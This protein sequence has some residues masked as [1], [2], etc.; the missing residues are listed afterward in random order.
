MNKK[1]LLLVINSFFKMESLEIAHAWS[2]YLNFKSLCDEGDSDTLDYFFS[3]IEMDK[4]GRL[5][6]RNLMAKNGYELTPCQL[7][8]YI[9]IL[10]LCI[11]EFID[12]E[13]YLM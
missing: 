11:N 2:A 12:N 6:L 13:H 3:V 8:Q 5:E 10:R 7:E 4:A 1:Q 9:F